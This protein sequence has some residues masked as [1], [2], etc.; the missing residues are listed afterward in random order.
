MLSQLSISLSSKLEAP[1]EEAAFKAL[2]AASHEPDTKRHAA[3]TLMSVASA[4]RTPMFAAMCLAAEIDSATLHHRPA[5]FVMP[6][7]MELARKGQFVPFAIVGYL[8]SVRSAV[9][10]LHFST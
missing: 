1:E 4:T 3:Q 2:A 5:A 7:V 10:S 6:F 9:S 8:F